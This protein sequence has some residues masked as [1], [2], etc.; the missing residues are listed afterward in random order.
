MS[1]FQVRRNFFP[2]VKSVT[3]VFF[4]SGAFSLVL[5]M[6]YLTSEVSMTSLSALAFRAGP[7]GMCAGER[8]VLIEHCVL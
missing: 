1:E 6:L 3:F 2:D 4:F 5:L 7:T 8:A